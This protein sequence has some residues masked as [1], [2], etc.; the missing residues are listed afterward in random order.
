MFVAIAK[1]TSPQK[2]IPWGDPLVVPDHTLDTLELVVIALQ[3]YPLRLWKLSLERRVI[4]MPMPMF[5]SQRGQRHETLRSRHNKP[6]LILVC[7]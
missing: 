2:N 4:K 1:K 7:F 6:G 5:D 3:S